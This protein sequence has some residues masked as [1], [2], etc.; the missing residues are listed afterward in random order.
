METTRIPLSQC[1]ERSYQN[2]KGLGD[3]SGLARERGGE[4]CRELGGRLGHVGEE[5]DLLVLEVVVDGGAADAGASGNAGAD[6]DA[7]L[8][9]AGAA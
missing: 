1:V 3:V 7:L 4:E 8:P 2:R 6:P 5:E 9:W